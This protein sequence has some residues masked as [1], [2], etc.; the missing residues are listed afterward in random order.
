MKYVNR[1]VVNLKPAE[2]FK[3]WVETLGAE[4]PEDWALEGGAYLLDEQETE[5]DLNRVIDQ[6]AREMME[7]EL[8]AW[9][10]D[11][12]RWPEERGVNQLREWFYVQ[13]AVAAFDLGKEGLM[14]ADLSEL[15]VM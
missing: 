12:A 5:D 2:P 1:C 13:I 15:D 6:H 7:N 14:R 4:L 11:T 8:A 3:T 10:E 9:E